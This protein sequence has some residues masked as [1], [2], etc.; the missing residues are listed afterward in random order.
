MASIYRVAVHASVPCAHTEGPVYDQRTG[1]LYY[2]DIL[3]KLLIELQSDG[4]LIARHQFSEFTTAVGLTEDPDI[5][6]VAVG[7]NVVL[8][9]RSTGHQRALARIPDPSSNRLNECK[10]GPDGRF[11]AGTMHMGARS[12]IASLYAIDRRGTV[13]K[14]RNEMMIANGMA[15]SI[16]GS[17]MYH[18][19][20]MARLGR[21]IDVYDFTPG[22]LELQP[23]RRITTPFLNLEP[24]VDGYP[25]VL[26]GMEIDA[27]GNLWVAGYGTGKIWC[28]NP[29]TDGVL[30]EICLNP[31]KVTSCSFGVYGDSSVL[32]VSTTKEH[33]SDG[34]LARYP[35][36]GSIYRIP[37]Q[38]GGGP[39]YYF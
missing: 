31:P 36:S 22:I 21:G 35:K 33:M 23:N 15:W 24:K 1:R 32:F 14:L 7:L 9:N 17:T 19:D 20:S 29:S 10:V 30:A 3:G 25:A 8:Y 12:P 18:I 6:V 2:V 16:D 38:I 39:V 13:V 5:L 26:D 37:M 34:E 28:V 27:D 11:Y 4:E